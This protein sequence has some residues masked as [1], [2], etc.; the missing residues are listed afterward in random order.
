MVPRHAERCVVMR[1]R[2]Y[3]WRTGRSESRALRSSEA[4]RAPAEQD[5]CRGVAPCWRAWAGDD[6]TATVTRALTRGCARPATCVR[7]PS[8][9]PGPWRRA[10]WRGSCCSSTTTRGPAAPPWRPTWAGGCRCV[11]RCTG[12][13]D[14]ICRRRCSTAGDWG[15]VRVVNSRVATLLGPPLVRCAEPWRAFFAIDRRA[16]P[17]PRAGALSASRSASS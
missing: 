6:T 12:R 7:W 13:C 5:C 8:V 14:S 2:R 9:W 4:C 17:D 11:W 15:L 3:P 16:L 10:A 1:T